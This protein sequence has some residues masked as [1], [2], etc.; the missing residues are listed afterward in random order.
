MAAGPRAAATV[1]EK[2]RQAAPVPVFLHIDMDGFYAQVEMRR[3]GVAPDVPFVLSQ[4]GN[5]IAVNYPA[6][7]Y[8]IGRMDSLASA[9]QKCAHVQHCHVP[10]FANGEREWRY[11]PPGNINKNSHKVSLEPYREASRRIFAILTGYDESITVEKAGID[12]AFLDVSILAARRAVALPLGVL[13]MH[14]LEAPEDRSWVYEVNGGTGD[15]R[16]DDDGLVLAVFRAAGLICRDLRRAIREQL[17]YNCSAGI[18]RNHTLAKFI[19]ATNKPNKQSLLLPK[20][21]A[22]FLAPIPFQKLRGFGG[23]FG[24]E[25]AQRFSAVTCADMRSVARSELAQVVGSEEAADG[26]FATL[27]GQSDTKLT[28]RT[29]PKSLLAQKNFAPPVNDTKGMRR[30]IDVLC[31]ELETRMLHLEDEFQVRPVNVNVK[32]SGRGLRGSGEL[33]NKSAPMPWP[34]DAQRVGDVVE[35]VVAS[36]FRAAAATSPN[37]MPPM[38]NC[39]MLGATVMRPVGEDFVGKAARQPGVDELFRRVATKS[40]PNSSSGDGS[41]GG[42]DDDDVVV[43]SQAP[44]TARPIKRGRNTESPRTEAIDVDA[45]Q[46]RPAPKRSTSIQLISSSDD[47]VEASDAPK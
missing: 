47:D 41:G 38:V 18:A 45:S 23:K 46:P 9:I 19:S 32:L 29:A 21:S 10:T 31:A 3:L 39:V 4:W 14:P 24:A 25:L 43:M 42:G 33:L 22:A 8:G 5:L 34:P 16:G 1:E 6:K 28:E 20:D 37:K 30:W 2:A 15:A 11:H 35:G 13:E 27:R 36:F 40:G 7:A 12:E 44:M 26:V 17:G